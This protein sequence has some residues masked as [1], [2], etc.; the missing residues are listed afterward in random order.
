MRNQQC[1]I[2]PNGHCCCQGASAIYQCHSGGMRG[3]AVLIGACI[4]PLTF[5]SNTQHTRTFIQPTVLLVG[6]ATRCNNED[7]ACSTTSTQPA[8]QRRKHQVRAL[9]FYIHTTRHTRRAAAAGAAAATNS[10]TACRCV[11]A[12]SLQH[13]CGPQPPHLEAILRKRRRLSCV[14]VITSGAAVVRDV[15]VLSQ[16]AHV[17]ECCKG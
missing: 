5:H 1:S 2:R 14:A 15:D 17:I 7:T 16:H 11:D 3:G 13:A 6:H 12:L 8:A 10:E 4:H 9:T